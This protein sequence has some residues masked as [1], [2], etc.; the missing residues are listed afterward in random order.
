MWSF[1]YFTLYVIY[2]IFVYIIFILQ[3]DANLT[4]EIEWTAKI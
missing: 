3:R 2:Y 1:I 4:N